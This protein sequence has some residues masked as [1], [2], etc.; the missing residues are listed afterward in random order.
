MS[1]VTFQMM[2]YYG[3]QRTDNTPATNCT[4]CG[5]FTVTTGTAPNRIFTI[6]YGTIYFSQTNTTHTLDYEVN[7]YKRAVRQRSTSTS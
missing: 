7:L 5:I 4:D 3:D 1:G 6:E 2:P